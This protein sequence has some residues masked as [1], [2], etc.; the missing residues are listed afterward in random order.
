MKSRFFLAVV[1]ALAA[2]PAC[3]T[4]AGTDVVVAGDGTLT[5]D[6]TI[7]D[8]K[9]PRDCRDEAADSI[10]IV[11]TD[12]GG[13]VVGEFN[14]VCEAFATSISL[15]PGSYSGDAT[16]LSTG[17]NPRTTAVDLGPFTIYGN[18]EL[19]VPIDFPLDSFF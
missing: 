4:S 5:V 16:L 1:G 7:G 15:A 17:G 19:V 12:P 9:D 6:W 2:L 11:V 3:T 10:D 14:D 18:D 13:G 8:A